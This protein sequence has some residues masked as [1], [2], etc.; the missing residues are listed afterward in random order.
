VISP[1]VG[2]KHQTAWLKLLESWFLHVAPGLIPIWMFSYFPKDLECDVW[3]IRMAASFQVANILNKTHFLPPQY[4]SQVLLLPWDKLLKLSLLT[5]LKSCHNYF[6]IHVVRV[7]SLFL[8]FWVIFH[9]VAFSFACWLTFQLF[10]VWG[11]WQIEQPWT[12]LYMPLYGDV[13]CFLASLGM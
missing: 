11:Y 5:L 3:D 1:L 7:N 8:F 12:F 6:E 10:A 2:I 9:G 13:L 4:F